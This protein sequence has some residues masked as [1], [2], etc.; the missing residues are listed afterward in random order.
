M[1]KHIRILTLI[2]AIF[3]SLSSMAQASLEIL[4]PRAVAEGGKFNVTVRLKNGE[5]KPKAPEIPN[6]KLLYEGGTSTQQSIT[7]SGGRQESLYIVDYTYVYQALKAGTVTIPAVSVNSGGKQLTSNT[8][9]LTILPPD[10]NSQAQDN[11]GGRQQ[12][13]QTAEDIK[14]SPEDMFIRV[15]L[16]RTQVYEQEPIV[17]TVKIYS[18]LNISAFRTLNQPTFEGFFSEELPVSR[19]PAYEHING[20]NYTSL[21]LRKVILYPQKTGKLNIE[22]GK[23]ELTLVQYINRQIGFGFIDRVPVE[24]TINTES[25]SAAVTVIPLPAPRPASF[26]GAVGSF[27]AKAEMSPLELRTNEATSYILTVKGTGNLKY[28][29]T[30]KIEIPEGFDSFTP[31][32]DIDA[33]FTGSDMSGT[34]TVNYTLVPQHPGTFTIP[35]GIFSYFNPKDKSYHTIDLEPFSMKV[36]QGAAVETGTEQTSIMSGMTDIRHLRPIHDSDISK[37]PSRIFYDGWYW[38]LYA[39][40]ALAL[41]ATIFAYRRHIRLS[42]DVQG[43]KLA[44]ANKMA[45]KRLRTAKQF[46]AKKDSDKFYMELNQAMTGY[47][48]DKLGIPASQLLRENISQKLAERGLPEYDIQSTINILDECEMARFTP[49]HSESEMSELFNKANAAIKA[50]ESAKKPQSTANA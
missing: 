41:A 21:E 45:A 18:K 11:G 47:L 29:T 42:Q 17:A 22:S 13:A 15:H 35:A 30:P 16:N 32:T 19:D 24:K 23:Y 20:N 27:T 9:Q 28:L 44:R 5:G 37:Q 7:F 1:I 39:L 25:N 3:A 43:R 34:Y 50:I 2:I 10:Q 26:S 38:A 12:Q 36:A 49:E 46:M 31:K 14:I 4:P 6:C 48:S 33:H 40:S 8:V